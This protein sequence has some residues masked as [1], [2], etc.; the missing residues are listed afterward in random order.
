MLNFIKRDKFQEVKIFRKYLKFIFGILISIVFLYLAVRK[1]SFSEILKIILSANIWYIL[2]GIFV[3]FL[4]LIVRS[5]RWRIILQKKE[6]PVISFFKST[7]VGQA[8]NNIFPFRIGDLVQAYFLG[9]KTGLSKSMIFSTVLMERMFDLFPPLLII[10]V[11]SYFVFLPE[12][13]SRKRFLVFIFLFLILG[14]I[15]LKSQRLINNIVRNLFPEGTLKSKIL[16]LIDNFYQSFKLLNSPSAIFYIVFQTIFL[17]FIYSLC[18]FFYLKALNIELNVLSSVLIQAIIAMSV[19]IPS[20]PGYVGTW[21]F[22]SV[23]ALSIFGVNKTHALSFG[24]VFHFFSWIIVT[25]IGFFVILRTG[26]SF[27]KLQQPK[28]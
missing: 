3:G 28:D 5:F 9:Y 20:S 2:L 6:I 8:V 22:F 24:L 4:A 25:S 15:F 7:C 16:D 23:L 21:E 27:D 11:G 26:L 17:W 10:L 1:V 14:Y 18:V 12:S 19:V 13:I